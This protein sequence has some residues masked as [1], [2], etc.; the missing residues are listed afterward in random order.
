MG[1]S[2]SRSGRDRSFGTHV[3]FEIKDNPAL[4]NI[5]DDHDYWGYTPGHPDLYHYHDPRD[6]VQGISVDFITPTAVQNPPPGALSVRSGPGITYFV[7]DGGTVQSTAV[8]NTIREN[9]EFVAFK[10]AFIEG[11][12]WYYIH[13]PST[14]RPLSGSS[15]NNGP[16]GGWVSGDIVVQNPFA[17][18]IEILGVFQEGL[19]VRSGPSTDFSVLAKTYTGQRFVTYDPPVNGVGCA[20]PWYKIHLPNSVRAPN[21]WIC[22][23][24]AKVTE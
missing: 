9:R 14:N 21:G 22:G 8:I 3:H 10:R 4:G 13:L 12:Y 11:G 6:C 15:L 24:F 7:T 17:T 16:N 20:L 23:D 1:N 18:Q 5:A 19:P 2:S